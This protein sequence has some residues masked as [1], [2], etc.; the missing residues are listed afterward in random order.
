V[1]KNST[2]PSRMPIFPLP[3]VVLF[4]G[5]FLPLHIFEPRYRNMI[6]D[7]LKGD[8][9]IGMVLLR[10]MQNPTDEQFPSTYSTGCAG[11]ITHAEQLADGRYNVVLRGYEK[12]R[13][14]AEDRQHSYRVADIESIPE[15]LSTS[16]QAVLQTSRQRMELLL[17]RRNKRSESALPRDM[18]DVELVNTLSQYLEFDPIEKQALLESDGIISRCHALI[19]LLQMHQLIS[20]QPNSLRSTQ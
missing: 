7:A 16:Q 4:P 11:L 6:G 3:N 10:E 20:S 18:P 5:V 8:R 12:F 15:P 2:L 13:I 1:P 14:H 19:D 17:D 9:L